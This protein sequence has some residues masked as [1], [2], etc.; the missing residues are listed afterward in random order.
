MLKAIT[1]EMT[2]MLMFL[3][4]RFNANGQ[5][6]ANYLSDHAISIDDPENLNESIYQLLSSYQIIMMGEIHGTNEPAQFII[7]LTNLLTSN[8]DSVQLGF[9]I[10][11]GQMTRF[12]SLQTDSSIYTSDFFL[13][14]KMESGRE[15]MAWAGIISKF[16]DNPRVRLFFYDINEGEGKPYQRDNLMYLNIKK[17]FNLHPSWKMIT[18]SGNAH[19]TFAEG[20]SMVSWLRDDKSLNL[21][22]K[23]CSL[24]LEYLQGTCRADFGNG[25]EVKQLGHPESVYDT[26]LP[27]D[28]YFVLMPS[29][30]EYQYTGFFYTKYITAATMV[31]NH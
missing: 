2:L 30:S 15:S 25:L 3:V 14:S 29:D 24:N 6:M 17:Q 13:H 22:S 16:K 27:F 1:I 31:N 18:L 26:T 8:G 23:I 10:P 7:G 4:I 12:I 28:K 5:N 9:E 11:A 21:S 20:N 19:N